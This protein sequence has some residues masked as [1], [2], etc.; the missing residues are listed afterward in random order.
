[1]APTLIS[2]IFQNRLCI[3]LIQFFFTHSCAGLLRIRANA[4]A[5]GKAKGGGH[6]SLVAG[7][8][9]LVLDL[10]LVPQQVVAALPCSA[11][12]LLFI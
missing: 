1:M 9:G 2:S 11:K 6:Q 7:F 8:E 5:A 10:P 3:S 4:E 12:T